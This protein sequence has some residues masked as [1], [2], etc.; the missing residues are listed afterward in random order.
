MQLMKLMLIAA[1]KTVVKIDC[2]MKYSISKRKKAYRSKQKQFILYSI[3]FNEYEN[4]G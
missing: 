3:H 4:V 2:S 1:I